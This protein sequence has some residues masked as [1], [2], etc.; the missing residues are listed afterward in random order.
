MDFL[1]V[2]V[3]QTGD[4]I[5]IMEFTGH[6]DIPIRIVYANETIERLSGYTRQELLDP[7]NP[8]LRIQSQDP[9]RY[10]K[11]FLELHAG[12][13][14]HLELELRG[15]HR[16]TWTQIRL[17][18]LQHKNGGVT[19]YVAVLRDISQRLQAQTEREALYR[20]IEQAQNG[21][22]ILELPAID[23]HS[24]RVKYVN[25]VACEMLKMSRERMVAVGLAGSI[26]AANPQ[27]LEQ[28]VTD[29]LRG[30]TFDHFVLARRGDKTKRWIHVIA[31]PIYG[32]S[33]RVEQV[34][35]T[36]LDAQEQIRKNQLLRRFQSILSHAPCAHKRVQS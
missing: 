1:E 6:R 20:A 23:P 34:A 27:L 26:F 22:C 8:Y 13:P 35:I 18:P 17:S 5:A 33:G 10:E 3:E 11:L 24:Y 4:G 25:D 2:A 31:S 9:A 29:M 15:K 19:H 32:A 28:L 30:A 7:S 36:Y 21:L 16:A 12:R 14:V